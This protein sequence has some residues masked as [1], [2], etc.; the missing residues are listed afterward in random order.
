MTS[1]AANQ[2]KVL[3]IAPGGA[4]LRPVTPVNGRDRGRHRSVSRR[5]G[6]TLLGSP[7]LFHQAP[8]SASDH[9]LLMVC[10]NK[11]MASNSQQY[12]LIMATWTLGWAHQILYIEER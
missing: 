7:Y 1:K 2:P 5:V 11:I 10:S 6:I 9:C 12:R 4:T 3:P 8:F